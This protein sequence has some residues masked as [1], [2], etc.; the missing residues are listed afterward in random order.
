MFYDLN[1]PWPTCTVTA[2]PP[3]KKAKKTNTQAAPTTIVPDLC[4]NP[5]DALSAND[6]QRLTELTYEL[7]ELGY[8]TVAYNQTV[9]TKYDPSTHPNPFP[10]KSNVPFPKLDPRT[11]AQ[12][13]APTSGASLTQ[14]SRLTLVLDKD[15]AIKGG[16]G[17]VATNSIALQKY[18]LLAAQPQTEATFQH[19][20]TTLSELKPFSIDIISLDLAAAP[21][22]PFYLKRST[23]GAAL[24]NGAVFEIDYSA[25]V[26]PSCDQKNVSVLRRNIF[27][28]ARDI[29][30]V[31]N[32]KG[33]ILS[34]GA[35]NA[36]GL[37]APY[38]V[39]NLATLMGITPI[40]AKDTLSN[41][42]KSLLV[43]ARTRQT[44]RGAV[45]QPT[46]VR[47]PAPSDVRDAT[48]MQG[49]KRRKQALF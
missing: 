44:F 49:R 20:C 19:A 17:F 7:S 15:H 3:T 46:L 26:D 14:L 22:L 27:S 30:R 29:L 4:G 32:G 1:I 6:R 8:A 12:A 45:S 18:D 47:T 11:R 25:A 2:A 23:V 48:A 10:L 31:T 5:L 42:C 13:G 21:R 9:Y 41:T 34:S 16:T 24:A 35:R 39:M 43:R 38:D 28:G 37:R 36:L 33:V 40:A